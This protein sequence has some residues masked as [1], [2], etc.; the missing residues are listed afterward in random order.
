MRQ[1]TDPSPV[2]DPPP[3]ANTLSVKFQ[4]V[5]EGTGIQIIAVREG[6]TW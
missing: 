1:L 5:L 3:N 6:E 2:K 4:H